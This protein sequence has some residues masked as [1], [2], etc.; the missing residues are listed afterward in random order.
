MSLII[1]E[2]QKLIKRR[3]FRVI[4]FLMMLIFAGVVWFSMSEYKAG[5]NGN[6][7]I[8]TAQQNVV[9]RARANISGDS[10]SIE[11]F[12]Y[13]YQQ[14]V[15]DV[16]DSFDR[17]PELTI[18]VSGWDMLFENGYMQFF[19]CVTIIV[20]VSE[21][22]T[23]DR[24]SGFSLL[25]RTCKKGRVPVSA[26]KMLIAAMFSVII[27]L[28]YFCSAFVIIK[29]KVGLSGMSEPIQYV[30]GFQLCPLRI[31]V[32]QYLLIHLVVGS[33]GYL[34]FG[35]IISLVT[36]FVKQYSISYLF[37]GAL[38]GILYAL[39]QTGIFGRNAV[40]SITDVISAMTVYP[41][42]IRYRAVNIFDEPFSLISLLLIIYTALTILGCCMVIMMFP[43]TKGLGTLR[44]LN[45]PQIRVPELNFR[46]YL[47]ICR[48]EFSKQLRTRRTVM[49]I[50]L[51]TIIK[52]IAASEKFAPDD[53]VDDKFY[54]Q[55]SERIEGSITNE[56][57]A[58]IEAES[59]YINGVLDRHAEVDD[60]FAS[61]K[62]SVDGYAA[63]SKEYQYAVNHE[64][65]L[66]KIQRKIIYAEYAEQTNGIKL[67]IF[68]DTG[69]N[70]MFDSGMD[71]LLL[72]VILLVGA[73]SYSVEYESKSS[74]WS[75]VSILRTT[76]NGRGNTCRNKLFVVMTLSA[77][78]DI[79]YQ[80]ID[81]IFIFKNYYMP[82]PGA[83]VLSLERFAGTDNISLAE[84]VLFMALARLSAVMFLSFGTFVLSRLLH[85]GFIAI[86]IVAVIIMLPVLLKAIGICANAGIVE[87]MNFTSAY[88][89]GRVAIISLNC[90]CIAVI[91]IVV[92]VMTESGL[93]RKGATKC[94]AK[95]Q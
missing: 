71:W 37:G 69:W 39:N 74:S 41:L 73:E 68:Y 27:G 32:G 91:G 26:V 52:L 56:T 79:I 23:Q 62:I 53:M 92:L 43:N 45:L 16:Y 86:I 15:I 29:L 84:Y 5:S 63:Y 12:E 6:W 76:R 57:Y 4:V 35:M 54:R 47:S 55:Y 66:E 13:A 3:Y 9:S 38:Y 60:D 72:I 1:F 14:M 83:S 19:V 89:G 44:K 11:R 88:T 49:L 18:S 77:V 34:L 65:P 22:F 81:W 95:S 78:I 93:P 21:I 31:S 40:L 28:L 70:L 94:E 17:L 64:K 20:A 46:P 10:T 48:F 7:E 36:C 24:S 67:Q 42:F 82:I 25:L 33:T 80:A 75:F 30:R 90:F 2:T 8:M 50:I 85:K 59:S 51:V 61:G 87:L 58:F